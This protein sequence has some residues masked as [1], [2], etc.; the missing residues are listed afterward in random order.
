MKGIR[1]RARM[2]RIVAAALASSLATALAAPAF[3][4]DDLL[5]PPQPEQLVAAADAPL[6]AWVGNERGVRNLWA[7]RA[8][9]FEPRRLSA[10][11]RDDGQLL[12]GLQL[13]R[14]GRW[15]VYVRGNKA[16]PSG[17]QGNP[18]GDPDGR[19]QA[20]WAVATDGGDAPRRVA[21]GGAALLSPRGDAV[22]VQQ[23]RALA[24]HGLPGVAPPWWCRPALL[25]LRG[26][27]RAAAFSPDGRTLAFVS[28][29]GDR[30][31]VGAL[32]LH[33]RAVRWMGPDF[34]R[35][36][37]PAFSPDGRRIAFLRIAAGRPQAPY[38]LSRA[39][40]FEIWTADVADGRARRVFA[41]DA[42]AGGYE[43]Y[44][45]AATLLW[46]GD[47]RL[48]FASEHDGW[49]RWYA[50]SPEGGAPRALSRGRC[51]TE[52]V[53]LA[54][55][56]AL[57]FSGNCAQPDHRQL[58]AVDAGGRQR[59]LTPTRGIASEP[60]AVAGGQWLA[61]RHADAQLPTAIAVL[62]RA[63]GAPRRIFPARLPERFPLARLRAPRAIELTAADGLRTRAFVFEPPGPA[64]ARRAAI[65]YVHGGPI[66]QTLPGWH[67]DSYFAHDYAMNQW[68]ASQGYVVLALNFRSGTGYGQAFRLAA[69]QGPR[70]ASEYRDVLAAQ[71]WLAARADVDPR[72]I[73]IHGGSFG[74]FLTA[75]ALA[76][77]SAK[78]AAGVGRHGVH[79]WREAAKGG[80]NSALWGLRPDELELAWRSSP[81]FDAPRWRSPLLLIHGDDDRAV[82]YVH[83][84]ALAAE[85]RARGVAVETLA[86]P[87]E[88][89]VFARH[90]SWLRAHRST[91]AFF[92]R[93]LPTG[94]D[95]AE[96]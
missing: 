2:A 24:C 43:Q 75:L 21:A 20:V 47:G 26:R 86:L 19:E 14:D 13:S 52:T 30:A 63:G 64:R 79:D 78:F 11:D 84:L 67:Y 71:A 92:R 33:A 4:I 56:G 66:W 45:D 70:G 25:N 74:G 96:P 68:L 58:F 77:D 90:A 49:R 9:R 39:T 31:F 22:V 93:H 18:D 12:S 60:V 46:A 82:R 53:A 7:A 44:N 87:D 57:V 32:D 28:D 55:D 8:P 94:E 17:Q 54:A 69:R 6:I 5:A 10:Y 51:E 37:E 65:V 41:S 15:L 36:S 80:D 83:S 42:R 62:P 76:R 38:D 48:L 3:D 35:D 59:Q 1:E 34:N 73:G 29:R 72:R 85:L 95:A 16:D 23:S 88:D 50:L 91:M 27:N 81:A 61:L 40:P 89:H